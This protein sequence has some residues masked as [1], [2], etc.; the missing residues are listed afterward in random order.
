[1]GRKG[2]SLWTSKGEGAKI[3]LIKAQNELDEGQ[4]IAERIAELTRDGYAYND[5]AILYRTN[6]VEKFQLKD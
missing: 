1:M 5:F 3:K 6:N 2:K 4:K